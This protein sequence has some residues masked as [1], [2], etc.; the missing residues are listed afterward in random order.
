MRFIDDDGE[1]AITQALLAENGLLCI[2]EG[3][4]GT[5]DDRHAFEHGL[6]QLLTLRQTRLLAINSTNHAGLML[7]LLN[8]IL[9]LLVQHLT[10]GHHNHTVEIGLAIRATHTDQRMRSPGDGIGFT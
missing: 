10:V 8:C 9:Q 2:G 5:N 6:G 4:Q 1:T 7:D 3:L